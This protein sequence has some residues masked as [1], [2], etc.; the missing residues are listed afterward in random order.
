MQIYRTKVKIPKGKIRKMN[1]MCKN[2][3]NILEIY[4]LFGNKVI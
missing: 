3:E 2:V 1:K 4:L